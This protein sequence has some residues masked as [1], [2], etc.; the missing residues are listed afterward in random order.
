MAVTAGVVGDPDVAAVLAALDMAAEL[1]RAAG[2][3]RR[4][5]HQ[6]AQADVAG[7]GPAESFAM[8][9]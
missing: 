3:D 9:V 5:D 6:L 7:V 4:H 1:R 8:T 2:L